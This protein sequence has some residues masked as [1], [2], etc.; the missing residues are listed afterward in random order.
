MMHDPRQSTT[1]FDLLGSH[2]MDEPVIE[3]H[4]VNSDGNKEGESLP[5]LENTVELIGVNPVAYQDMFKT[6]VV[7][8]QRL[9]R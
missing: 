5:F 9:R 1:G 7:I 8:P 4:G 2:Q 6:R 3:F